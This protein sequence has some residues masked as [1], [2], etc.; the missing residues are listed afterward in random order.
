MPQ[1]PE[2]EVRAKINLGKRKLTEN[3]HSATHLMH[4]ALRQILGTHVEQKGSLVNADYLRF[5]FSHFS[6]VS[7]EEIAA[8]EKLVNQ[9]IR[10]NIAQRTQVLPI[11]EAKKLGAMALFGE[12][13]GDIVRVVVM[14]PNYSIEL[15]GGTHVG[16]TGALGLFK[17]K[18]ESLLELNFL[19]AEDRPA[20]GERLSLRKKATAAPKLV[21]RENYNLTTAKPQR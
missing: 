18:S 1:H 15:C 20:P 19:G 3:N 4:A 5:D 16:S 9:K 7:A 21:I 13:Y 10:E 17:F 6:K 12:K 8:I 11:N 2:G 14:D